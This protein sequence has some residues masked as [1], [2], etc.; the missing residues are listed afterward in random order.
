ML[1]FTVAVYPSKTMSLMNCVAPNK[2]N[3]WQYALGMRT[4][5][6]TKSREI[7]DHALKK[8]F[9]FVFVRHHVIEACLQ[10]AG[11]PAASRGSSEGY[12]KVWARSTRQVSDFFR[13]AVELERRLLINVISE[14]LVKRSDVLRDAYARPFEMHDLVDE[15]ILFLGVEG[16]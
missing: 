2:K 13:F 1:V 5:E 11:N 7:E 10:Y 12:C 3:W 4:S 9:N 15:E 16:K 14:R 8:C 6:D